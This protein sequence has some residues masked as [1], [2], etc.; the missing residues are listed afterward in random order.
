VTPERLQEPFHHYGFIRA[1]SE[2]LPTNAII[3]STRAGTSS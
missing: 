1:L 2:E 3:V